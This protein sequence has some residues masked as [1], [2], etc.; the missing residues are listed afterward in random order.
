MIRPGAD[1]I[2]ALLIFILSVGGTALSY[3]N[4]V[5]QDSNAGGIVESDIRLGKNDYIISNSNGCVGTF[6]TELNR[7]K[8]YSL[9]IN[10]VLW[11]RYQS[12][13]INTEIEIKADFNPLGQLLASVT[14]IESPELKL[15]L[16]TDQTNPIILSIDAAYSGNHLNKNISFK[17]PLTLVETK[18]GH[19][20]MSSPYTK[21]MKASFLNNA[22]SMLS[23]LGVKLQSAAM[24]ECSNLGKSSIDLTS[25]VNALS[26]L[27]DRVTLLE[28]YK[29]KIKNDRDRKPH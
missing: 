10:I 14:S 17:G 28:D 23:Q 22:P 24:N 21:V 6:Q 2:T 1:I 5:K 8:D 15:K 11:T 25:F 12:R 26:L 29:G 16:R 13:P 19:F 18:R 4:V 3:E 9:T 7:S 27:K 20:H